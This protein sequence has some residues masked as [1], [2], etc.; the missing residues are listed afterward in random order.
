MPNYRVFE[1]KQRVFI[2]S[3]RSASGYGSSVIRALQLLPAFGVQRVVEG[4]SVV[5]IPHRLN[6]AGLGIIV[7]PNWLTTAY[8]TSLPADSAVLGFG[9]QAP[10]NANVFWEASIMPIKN[11]TVGDQFA[12]VTHNE[13]DIAV[14]IFATANWNTSIFDS[15][16]DRTLNSATLYFGSSAS[17]TTPQIAWRTPD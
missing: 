11:I 17:G 5:T 12:V 9:S 10:A 13:N 1:A 15:T 6:Q 3:A 16:P 4:E 14:P 2:F 7:M 8:W